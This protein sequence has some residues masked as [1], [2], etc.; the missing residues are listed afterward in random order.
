[1]ISHMN[2]EIPIWE[3][4]LTITQMDYPLF[5]SYFLLFECDFSS[6]SLGIFVESPLL[7][8]FKNQGY[9]IISGSW[10]GMEMWAKNDFPDICTYIKTKI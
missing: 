5:H 6:Y 7:S 8:Q 10:D 4:I 3:H 1:M 2:R 9:H